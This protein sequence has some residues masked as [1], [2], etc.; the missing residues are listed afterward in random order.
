MKIKNIL[1]GLILLSLSI[2]TYADTEKK[3]YRETIDFKPEG[4]V[5]IQSTNGNIELQSWEK[6]QVDIYA[7]IIVTESTSRE[8]RQLLDTI[9]IAIEKSGDRLSIVPVCPSQ[10]SGTNFWDWIFGSHNPPVINFRVKVPLN[11]DTE[12]ESMNGSLVVEN[13]S[14]S[15]K[16]STINGKIRLMRSAGSIDAR[17][18][19]G[20]IEAT[21]KSLDESEEVKMRTVNGSIELRLYEEIAASV[22]VSTI[23]GAINTDLPLTIKGKL[24]KKNIEGDIN[25]GGGKIGLSTVNGGISINKY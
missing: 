18:T 16:A 12:L 7:E 19:N 4:S 11:T 22:H 23:N 9:D 3:E 8:A 25:G 15:T 10:K 6:D 5:Y 1:I 20:C 2:P 14:G 13:V 21:L 17:T 24:L